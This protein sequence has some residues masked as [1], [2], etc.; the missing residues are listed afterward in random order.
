MGFNR[1]DTDRILSFRDKITADIWNG[2]YNKKKISKEVAEKAYEKL[3][4]LSMSKQ[5]NLLKAPPKN[6][7][8][9]LTNDRTGQWSIRVNDKYRICFEPVSDGTGTY[10]KNVEFVD[11]H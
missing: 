1:I 9:R 7:L 8:E 6:H 5:L 3:V 11:Y 2:D 10:Y 4:Q